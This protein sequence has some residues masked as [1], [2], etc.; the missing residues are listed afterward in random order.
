MIKLTRKRLTTEETKQLTAKKSLP[1]R[2][3]RQGIRFS[4]GSIQRRAGYAGKSA[5]PL[6]A[7]KL[8]VIPLGGMEEV[9]RNCMLFEY[10]KDIII[11]DMGLQ[12]PEEDMPGI[13]YIIPNVECLKGKEKNIKGVIITHGH[14]DH[15][16]GIP[17]I[18]G[19]IGNPTIY[20]AKLTAGMIKKRQEEFRDAPPLRIQLVDEFSRIRLGKFDVEFFRVNHN[21]PDSFG[22]VIHTPI[23]TVIHTG[24]FK[25]DHSPVN[26]APAD[27]NRIAQFGARNVLALFSDSTDAEHPG[28][29]ISEKN[30]GHDL[31]KIFEEATGRIVIGTFASL[32]SRVQQ[33]IW[34]AEKYGKKVMIYGRSM[35]TNVEIAHQLG[36]L[37]IK[38]GT[39]V[40]EASY[41]KIPDDKLMVMCTGAQGERNAALMRIANDD[42][43]YLFV[44]E[45]D[46]FV[47]SSS[48]IP[49][50]ERTIQSLKDTLYKKGAKVMHYKMMDIHAGG[51]AKQEDLKLMIRLI[52]PKYFIP[53]EAN[54]YMLRI[55]GSLAESVGIPK[56]N[57]FIAMNGQV[58]EFFKYRNDIFG[59]LTNQ[60]IN[61]DYVMV[62]GLGVGDV[63][64][65]VLRDR[66]MM[67]EDGMF[68]VI[69][70]ISKQTG[71]LI[72]SPDL[73]SR[74]FV[75]MKE[76][77]VLIED[78]RQ[79]V[80]NILRDK[81]P[82]SGAFADHLKDKIRR[83][84]GQ[85]LFKKTKR[86]PMVLPV[87][88]EV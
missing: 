46:T 63:S 70:T 41:E 28:Y 65:I 14:Y 42:D 12:F 75:Y 11:I 4:S 35:K 36:Y 18:M 16:G 80:R 8:R 17:H 23:G 15:I 54:H 76:N 47:F 30:I 88:I 85:F 74:G 3:T 22:V 26:D 27:I 39:L 48:V 55:H 37:K 51:H 66:R 9:G 60:K 33:L 34:L 71:E 73:I 10:E 7:G 38:P 67:A 72:G 59:R 86:R 68:V 25:I 78:T 84:I 57:I 61:T 2:M 79:R 53:I 1:H 87:I 21:I 58:L 82:E 13:D 45:N 32:L 81:H 62:D 52:K 6:E 64:D 40:D 19:K 31:E 69:A 83:E 49:G 56:S 77:K 50:N 20:T 44:K 5:Y 43:K 24:D 29:Q